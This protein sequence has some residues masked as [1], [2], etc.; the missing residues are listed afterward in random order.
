L[1]L[2]L[3]SAVFLGYEFRGNHEHIL[4]SHFL[5]LPQPGGSGSCIYFPQEQGGSVIPPDT[6]FHFCRLLRLAGLRRSYSNPHPP[7]TR[8]KTNSKFKFKFK[9]KFKL[10]CD[11]R[12]VCQFALVSGGLWGPWPDFTFLWVTITFFLVRVGR[13]LWREDG[14]VICSAITQFQVQVYCDRRSVGQFALVSGGLWGPWPDFNFLCVTIT[15]FLLHV[16]RLHP[17]LPWTGWSRPKSKS[18]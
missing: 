17:Y 10:Y 7:A 13:P 16:G 6:G 12:S 15:F 18:H 2:G 9:F 8:L 14:S 4:L 11:R 3:A 1:L 5:R